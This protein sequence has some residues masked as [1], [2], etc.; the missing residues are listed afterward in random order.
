MCSITG[1]P[2]LDISIEIFKTG[3]SMRSFLILR[4]LGEGVNTNDPN[5]RTIF[6][7]L[8]SQFINKNALEELLSLSYFKEDPSQ[9]LYATLLK[10]DKKVLE[11]YLKNVQDEIYKKIKTMDSVSFSNFDII[12]NFIENNYKEEL[13]QLSEKHLLSFKERCYQKKKDNFF[14]NCQEKKVYP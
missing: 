8:N 10:K 12:Q 7:N 2:Y 3:S 6:I 11:A 9:S 4:F 1:K 14:N 13:Y 5:T